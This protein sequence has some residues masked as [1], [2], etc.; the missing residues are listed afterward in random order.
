MIFRVLSEAICSGVFREF[1][2]D[3]KK[4]LPKNQELRKST[5][6]N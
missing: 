4:A 3:L 6:N 1:F 5:A 2:A